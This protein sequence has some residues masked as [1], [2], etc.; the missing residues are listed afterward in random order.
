MEQNILSRINQI[1]SSFY[2]RKNGLSLDALRK[3]LPNIDFSFNVESFVLRHDDE[4][5][6]AFIPYIEVSSV[7]GMLYE[8]NR[9]A[10]QYLETYHTVVLIF[11][12]K[13][14]TYKYY[15]DYSS[16]EITD[17]RRINYSKYSD[18]EVVQGFISYYKKMVKER[19]ASEWNWD[20]NRVELYHGFN[21]E[22]SRIYLDDEVLHSIFSTDNI[23]KNKP[24]DDLF[25]MMLDPFSVEDE[26]NEKQVYCRFYLNEDDE[27]HPLLYAEVANDNTNAITKSLFTNYFEEGS[28]DTSETPDIYTKRNALDYIFKPYLY[29]AFIDMDQIPS[30]TRNRILENLGKTFSL[31]IQISKNHSDKNSSSSYLVFAASKKKTSYIEV[32]WRTLSQTNGISQAQPNSYSF[33]SN[34]TINSPFSTKLDDIFSDKIDLNIHCVGQANFICGST[35]NSNKCFVFDCGFPVDADISRAENGGVKPND[36]YND[37]FV[38]DVNPNVIMIS[39][40]DYDHFSGLFSF[41]RPVWGNDELVFIAPYKGIESFGEWGVTFLRY[42]K[43][44]GSL[45]LIETSKKSDGCIYRYYGKGILFQ[46]KGNTKNERSL[47]LKLKNTI[48]TGDC[49]DRYWPGEFDDPESFEH[50]ILPHHGAKAVLQRS[51]TAISIYNNFKSFK[52]YICAGF[53]NRFDHPIRLGWFDPFDKSS[54]CTIQCTNIADTNRSIKKRKPNKIKTIIIEDA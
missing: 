46:G 16:Q 33:S 44:K 51:N 53:N 45:C 31:K 50:I 39:H 43:S 13:F 35:N 14:N 19:P 48:L 52:I 32:K 42:L 11:D 47:L 2:N 20:L 26:K 1:K 4:I 34:Q 17:L 38:K 22:Y 8:E 49:S 25:K 7:I 54:L 40:W 29:H 12:P 28:G 10:A 15:D 21:G 9:D 3:L 27:D 24:L 23:F 41:D 6:I 30:K 36:P 5:N 37:D 18:I